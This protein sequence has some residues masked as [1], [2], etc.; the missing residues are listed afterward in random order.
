MTKQES[1]EII[2]LAEFG[3]T[4]T[5]GTIW[6]K[7]GDILSKDLFDPSLIE[8]LKA[9][10]KIKDYFPEKKVVEKLETAAPVRGAKL[11]EK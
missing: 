8:Q 11:Q 2:V 3:T 1:T 6:G 9:D 10:G 7:P 4:V 5:T